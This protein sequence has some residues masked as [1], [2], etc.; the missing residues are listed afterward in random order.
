[1]GVLHGT[2]AALLKAPAQLHCGGPSLPGSR[3]VASG[4]MSFTEMSYPI[5][6]LPTNFPSLSL[7][8]KQQ[9]LK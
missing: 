3:L 9:R 5:I 6:S 8:R 1:S 2:G 4:M 7:G